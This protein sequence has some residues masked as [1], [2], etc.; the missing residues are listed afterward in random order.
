MTAKKPRVAIVSD[1]LVQRGGAERVVE[2]IAEIYPDAPIF[3]ILYSEKTGPASL[4][5][6]IVESPLGR[7]PGAASKHRWFLPFYAAA[8]ESFD[9]S[10]Y[11]VIISSHHTAAKGLLRHSNQRH[12]CYCHTPMRA[13]W[14]RPHEEL[15]TIPAPLRGMGAAL[16]RNLRVWDLAAASHVDQ[17][18]ANS[19]VTRTRITKH[20]GRFSTLLYPPIDVDRFTPAA[21]PVGD[22]YLVASRNVPYK[23]I[24]IA[25][26]AAAQAHRKLVIVGCKGD[27]PELNGPHVQHYGHV[28]DDR[29]LE[30]MRGAR[31]LLFPGFEDFG[32][33]PV[34]MMAC[35]RPVIAYG[36]GGAL[37]TVVDGVTG[38]LVAEQS[39][40][41]FADGMH[42][43][44]RLRF[45]SDTIRR[46]AERFS[47]QRFMQ[48][49]KEIVDGDPMEQQAS[50]LD[51]VLTGLLR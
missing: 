11:D 3:A 27:A 21:V 7:I 32:M 39:A 42:R 41:A 44:E 17:F 34:E 19:E 1:P 23:R 6:R 24:D 40:R 16:M 10:E 30:L 33:T 46:H 28:S 2:T 31:A 20:Y 51:P 13:L 47:K 49:F 12:I 14:E 18:V 26:A 25:V 5:D 4:K 9:L 35:G 37:E 43:F 15:R 45:E 29:L 8:V 36:K 22:Y 38:V 50:A 48:A